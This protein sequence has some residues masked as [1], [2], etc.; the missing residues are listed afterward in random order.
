M[1]E[2]KFTPT[3]KAN[4]DSS[5]A[6]AYSPVPRP[7]RAARRRAGAEGRQRHPAEGADRQARR[8]PLLLRGGDR[9]RRREERQT[10]RP[11]SPSCPERQLPRHGHDRFRHRRPTRCR[12][13]R[14]R[15]ARRSVQG[16]SALAG[17]D[18]PGGGRSVRPRHRGRPGG[19]E[20]QP[21]NRPDQR[22]L[23]RHPRRL[24]RGEAG[25]ARD[26]HRP[27]TAR[28]SCST[29]RTA[30]RRRRPGT[31]NGGGADPTNPAA[32]SSYAVNDPF[33]ATGCNKLG[34]KPKLKIKLF[35]PT[36]RNKY[37]RLK[38]ILEPARA[39]PTSPAPR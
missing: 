18:H 27:R 33:Q 37:P 39:T 30:P 21:G 11:T 26:R 6:G 23:R 3:Y 15:L 29:R 10:R 28:S 38:A 8:H 22:R 13:P 1:A 32:F 2:R 4:P 31:I 19:A 25:P 24:R 20:R 16:R 7:H 5:K 36:K 34:F 35:G 9:R 14:Q 17:D 12:L